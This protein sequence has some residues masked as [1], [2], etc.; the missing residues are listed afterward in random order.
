[1]NESTFVVLLNVNFILWVGI[2]VIWWPELVS[3]CLHCFQQQYLLQKLH[4]IALFIKW[5]NYTIVHRD[6][7]H[8][9]NHDDD[10]Y[11][12]RR[13]RS[14][15]RSIS[16]RDD[17]NCRSKGRSSR[18]SRPMSRSNS[19]CIQKKGRFIS[20]TPRDN[21]QIAHDVDSTPRRLKSPGRNGGSS[22]RSPSR[23]Y[24]FVKMSILWSLN[25]NFWNQ[26]CR[27]KSCLFD[28]SVLCYIFSSFIFTYTYPFSGSRGTSW[29][30]HDAL[31]RIPPFWCR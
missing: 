1:M 19:P 3:T 22:A 25:R 28:I 8:E 17:R 23:S 2:A 12:P 24:R 21:S 7:D 18:Q 27:L 16:P 30:H 14:Q 11:S 5:L 31:H 26:L 9:K 20:M 10:Y 4:C 15:S 6:R 29:K 13:S